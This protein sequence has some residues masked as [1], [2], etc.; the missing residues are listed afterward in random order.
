MTT[1]DA[2]LMGANRIGMLLLSPLVSG[3]NSAFDLFLAQLQ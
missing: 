1:Q 3:A 2:A